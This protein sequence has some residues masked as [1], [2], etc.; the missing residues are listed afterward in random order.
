MLEWSGMNGGAAK[1]PSASEN[2]TYGSRT[3]HF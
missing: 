3:Y 1:T 2:R